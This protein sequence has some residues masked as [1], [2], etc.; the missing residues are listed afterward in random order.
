MAHFAELDDN[1]IVLRVVVISN[2]VV[3]PEGTGTDN[4][5]L[6]IAKCQALFGSD[7]N[8]V[9]T[10]YNNNFRKRYAGQ[11]FWYDSENDIFVE[12][13]PGANWTLA[14][15]YVTAGF[16]EEWVAPVA[17]PDPENFDNFWWHEPSG[18][19]LKIE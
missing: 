19:W 10:S 5:A 15:D 3:D 8:W 6:G 7:T 4:E 2:D 11:G 12:P 9:Q 13:K 14:D 17:H 16:A 18:T 1:N